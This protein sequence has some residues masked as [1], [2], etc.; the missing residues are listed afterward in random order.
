MQIW[1]TI[2]SFSSVGK[3]DFF[4]L[5]HT[6]D[7]V[8][9]AISSHCE[10]GVDIE[11]IRDLDNSYLNISQHFFTPQEATNIVSLPRYEGQLLFGKCGRSKKLT[12]NIEVK[13]YL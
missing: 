12:S 1:Q 7:T 4:N 8:A 5:S 3:K 13:A 2:Y 6:I 10:L 11:Q 9:V